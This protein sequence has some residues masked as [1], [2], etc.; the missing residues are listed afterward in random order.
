M[1]P[2]DLLNKEVIL[3]KL[4]KNKNGFTITLLNKLFVYTINTKQNL[5]NVTINRN[6]GS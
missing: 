1:H 2:T 5:K 4:D 3:S 6:Q